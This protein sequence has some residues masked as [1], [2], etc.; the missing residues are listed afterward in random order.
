MGPYFGK[1]IY[2]IYIPSE[3]ALKYTFLINLKDNYESQE[4]L[5]LS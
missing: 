1:Y 2:G 4:S 3:S 5:S